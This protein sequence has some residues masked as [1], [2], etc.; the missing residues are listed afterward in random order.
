[1]AEADGT[2]TTAGE[3]RR[4]LSL[5]STADPP[6]ASL[7]SLVAEASHRHD[8]SVDASPAAQR[9]ETP[10]VLLRVLIQSKLGLEP[11]DHR[12]SGPRANAEPVPSKRA[13]SRRGTQHL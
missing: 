11:S 5:P 10:Q 6:D 8:S 3:H 4:Q 12:S 7:L 9:P 13:R 2:G 1:M